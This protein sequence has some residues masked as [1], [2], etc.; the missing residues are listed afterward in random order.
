MGL[1]DKLKGM[2]PESASAKA[3]RRMAEQAAKDRA[4]AAEAA[5]QQAEQEKAEKK[6]KEITF[7]KGG[8]IRGDGIAQRGKT[9]GRNV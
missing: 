2:V 1:M 5:K 9:R 7:R 8:A 6:V 3:D 4:A